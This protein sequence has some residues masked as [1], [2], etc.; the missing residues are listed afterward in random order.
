MAVNKFWDKE[1]LVA[2]I[3][4]NEKGDVIKIQ[5]VEKSGK[6]YVDVRTFYVDKNSGELMPGKGISIPS[7]LA[8]E[9]AND[10]LQSA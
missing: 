5:K 10:I 3:G 1:E 9:V 6:Q 7:D 2:E 4:K 8:D